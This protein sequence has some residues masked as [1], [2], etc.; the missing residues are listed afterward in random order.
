MLVRCLRTLFPA[1]RLN[2][3]RLLLLVLS[4]ISVDSSQC[5]ARR[6]LHLCQ[7]LISPNDG[8]FPVESTAKAYKVR[9]SNYPDTNKIPQL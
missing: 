6:G 9:E 7:T 4:D 8:V 5:L 3:S 1:S 2:P